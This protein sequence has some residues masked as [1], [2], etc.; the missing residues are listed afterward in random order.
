MPKGAMLTH[1]NLHHRLSWMKSHYDIG[2]EQT[3]IQKTSISFDVSVWEIFLPLISGATLVVAE[4]G[5][6]KDPYLLSALVK[7][8]DVNVIHFVPSMLQAFL[9]VS[10]IH[11]NSPLTMFF[12]S[13]EELTPIIVRDFYNLYDVDLVNLYG[14]TETSIDVSYWDCKCSSALRSIPIGKPIANTELYILN[15][16]LNPVAVGVIGELF[17]GGDGVGRGYLNNPGLTA[18]KF[19]PNPRAKLIGSRMYKSGDKAKFLPDGNIV[20]IGRVDH[21][22]KVRGQRIELGE[23]D[24]CLSEHEAVSQCI[25]L[26]KA[27]SIGQNSHLVSYIRVSDE[28]GAGDEKLTEKLRC[29]LKSKLPEYMVPTYIVEVH[30]FSLSENGKLDRSTLPEVSGQYEQMPSNKHASPLESIL[31]G[32]WSEVLN[33]NRS[34]LS[35]YSN[36]FDCGGHSLLAVKLLDLIQTKTNVRLT[37]EN[38]FDNETIFKQAEFLSNLDVSERNTVATITKVNKLEISYYQLQMLQ[39]YKLCPD[40]PH[41]N[42]SSSFLLTGEVRLQVLE[43]ALKSLFEK[44]KILR[45]VYHFDNDGNVDVQAR[46]LNGPIIEYCDSTGTIFD[47][48]NLVKIE[49]QKTFNLAMDLMARVKLFKYG[50]NKYLLIITLHHI[51]CDGWSLGILT[52]ELNNNYSTLLK[53]SSIDFNGSIDYFDYSSWL[54]ERLNEKFIERELDYWKGQLEGVPKLHNLPLDN[55]RPKIFNHE[56]RSHN[57][58]LSE[59]SNQRINE[60]IASS[61]ISIFIFL[62]SILTVLLYRYSGDEDMVIGVP[63]AN[64]GRHETQ[65]IV[66]YFVNTLPIRTTMCGNEGETFTSLL[67]RNRQTLLDA[68]NHQELPFNIL[69]SELAAS[70][71][72][73]FNP[74]FQ[75]MVGLQN[76]DEGMVDLPGVSI[77][78]MNISNDTC[79]FDLSITFVQKDG[80]LS[81]NWEYATCLFAESTIRTMSSR[82]ETLVNEILA[83]PG[84]NIDSV[85]FRHKG[86]LD[87]LEKLGSNKVSSMELPSFVQLFEQQVMQTPT[88]V[89]LEFDGTE[90]TYHQINQKANRIANFLRSKGLPEETAIGVLLERSPDYIASVLGI[91]KAAYVFVPLDLRSPIDRTK[92]MIENSGSQII[93]THDRLLKTLNNLSSE[94]VAMVS[95]DHLSIYPTSDVRIFAS[96]SYGKKLA[97]IMYTSGTTGKPKGVCIEHRQLAAYIASSIPVYGVSACDRV[98]QFSSLMF[99]IFIEELC[100][101]FTTGGTLVLRNELMLENEI[102]FREFISRH[103]ISVISIP[104]YFWH[105]LCSK[106]ESFFINKNTT[107]CTVIIG[108]EAASKAMWKKWSDTVGSSVRIF[109]TYGPTETVCVSSIYEMTEYASSYNSI[110]IGTPLEHYKFFVLDRHG[111]I[112]PSGIPGELVITGNA[113][114]RG[115]LSGVDVSSFFTLQIPEEN[116]PRA[117][118]TG[119]LVKQLPDG[120]YEYMGRIDSLVKIEGYRVD[121]TEIEQLLLTSNTVEMALV[122]FDQS[123]L[124]VGKLIAYCVMKNDSCTEVDSDLQRL[125]K[126]L[127]V[128]L[129]KYMLPQHI[130]KVRSFPL[131]ATGKIDRS[132]LPDPTSIRQ[133]SKVPT[134]DI[135]IFIAKTWSRVL[136]VNYEDCVLQAD[137]FQ[138]GG[139]SLNAIKVLAIIN[140]KYKFNLDLLVLY[141]FSLL[142][143]LAENIRVSMD[144]I[145][146]SNALAS[147]ND[148]DIEEVEI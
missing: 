2:P 5:L 79:K 41:Y 131:N 111:H 99:D 6:H 64:R 66:G 91:W 11:K 67:E 55:P 24:F 92:F 36:F 98:L 141:H 118:K 85:N 29:Y 3:F 138:L 83:E 113:V 27:N 1:K 87:E 143:E 82:Y 76:H 57:F 72:V 116:N 61:N 114:G 10:G 59:L 132:K 124:G 49:S 8:H 127:N 37:I 119:D 56:G 110:P 122:V 136:G 43:Q 23:I 52:E 115:Y 75:V 109:N 74:L 16:D 130:I 107:L 44:H 125:R 46:E 48:H 53:A 142:E 105:S 123:G 103:R 26:V 145:K 80:Q 62:H 100:L 93:I 137:F 63:V 34:E 45:T 86:E 121:L 25:T 148:D 33:V 112:C 15:D 84:I 32:L 38:V 126:Y 101:A 35:V 96:K 68:Y 65:D 31:I 77:E 60:F 94:G 54:N 78:R 21:Q 120:N 40:S 58:Q 128:K 42:I 97:Y 129:P 144:K 73:G 104:T 134:S 28:Q 19:I 133:D 13:G 108:G 102:A 14:P 146:V 50:P 9:E 47:L 90:F 95:I 106:M 30:E 20:F 135:E 17:I 22:V 4:P 117:Y 89:A 139:N 88:K 140:E 12:C 147:L 51:A 70:Q 18:E 39:L 7:K 81:M 71:D 69:A